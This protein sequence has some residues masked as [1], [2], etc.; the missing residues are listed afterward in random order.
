MVLTTLRSFPFSLVVADGGRAECKLVHTTLQSRFA[1]KGAL[2]IVGDKAYD[3]DPMDRELRKHDIELIAPHRNGRIS[4]KTQDGRSLRLYKQRWRVERFFSWLF[5]YRK[6][7]MRYER[8][9]ENFLGFVQL[10]CVIM[11]L[12]YF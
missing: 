1:L 8:K 7:A 3:N 4:K 6:C 5:N 10:A 2:R 9:A 11:L 12:R